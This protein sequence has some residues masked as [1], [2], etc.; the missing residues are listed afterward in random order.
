MELSEPELIYRGLHSCDLC[1]GHLTPSE[2]LAGICHA[3]RWPEGPRGQPGAP[4]PSTSTRRKNARK[5]I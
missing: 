1:G 4:R 2:T 3:C 5:P